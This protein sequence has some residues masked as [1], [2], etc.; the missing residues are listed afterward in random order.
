M[1]YAYVECIFLS[2]VSV[3]SCHVCC[4]FYAVLGCVI[5]LQCVTLCVLVLNALHVQTE[6]NEG[7]IT[8]HL[9]V[10]KTHSRRDEKITALREAE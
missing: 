1:R 6:V 9:Y 5:K 7:T 10:D 4:T 8:E 3:S 2:F